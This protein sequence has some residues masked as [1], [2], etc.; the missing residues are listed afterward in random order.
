MPLRDGEGEFWK[1]AAFC[2]QGPCHRQHP[3]ESSPWRKAACG[4]PVLKPQLT[5]S[6]CF[7]LNK[8]AEILG[9]CD[10]GKTSE[11]QGCLGGERRFIRK[12]GGEDLTFKPSPSRPGDAGSFSQSVKQAGDRPLQLT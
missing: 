3:A 9:R 4:D 6:N 2:R 11:T 7:P 10:N 8:T 5:D 12:E 1:G